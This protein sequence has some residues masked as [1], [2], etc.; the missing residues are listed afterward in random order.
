MSSTK[1]VFI[2]RVSLQDSGWRIYTVAL[3]AVFMM[4]DGKTVRNM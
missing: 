4:V 3:Y 1:T 2:I